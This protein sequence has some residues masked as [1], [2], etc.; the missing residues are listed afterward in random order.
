MLM[1]REVTTLHS[2]AL[3]HLRVQTRTV[4]WFL[5][6]ITFLLHRLSTNQNRWRAVCDVIEINI[7]KAFQVSVECHQNRFLGM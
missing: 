7:G 4:A 2:L 1:F 5:L 6:L 3:T